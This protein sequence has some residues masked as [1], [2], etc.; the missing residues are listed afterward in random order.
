MNTVFFDRL[1]TWRGICLTEDKY[2][3]VFF[4][5]NQFGAIPQTPFRVFEPSPLDRDTHRKMNNRAGFD[6]YI[7]TLFDYP[8]VVQHHLPTSQDALRDFGRFLTIEVVACPF[9]CWHCYRTTRHENV[10][11]ASTS[12]YRAMDIVRLFAQLDRHVAKADESLRVLRISGGEPFLVVDLIAEILRLI[13]EER[14]SFEEDLRERLPEC[15]WTETNLAPWAPGPDGRSLVELIDD[16]KPG[17]LEILRKH[18]DR[19]IIHPCFHGLE[20]ANIAECTGIESGQLTMADLVAGFRTLHELGFP[21]YPTFIPEACDPD[22]VTGLFESLYEIAPR[23]PLQT[24]LIQV[25][26]YPQAVRRLKMRSGKQG[27]RFYSRFAGL[28]RW[29]RLLQKHYGIDYAQLPRYLAGGLVSLQRP[30]QSVRED[31]HKYRPCLVILKST[32]RQEY[33]REMLTIIGAPVGYKVRESYDLVHLESSL[34]QQLVARSPDSRSVLRDARAIIVYTEPNRFVWLPIRFAKVCDVTVSGS[35]ASFDLELQEY[36]VASHE[37]SPD[38]ERIKKF[39]SNAQRKALDYFGASVIRCPSPQMAW[40]VLGEEKVFEDFQQPAPEADG[41]GHLMSTIPYWPDT[42]RLWDEENIFIALRVATT[43]RTASDTGGDPLKGDAPKSVADLELREGE[44]L[45]CKLV[46]VIPRFDSYQ[47]NGRSVRPITSRTLV[48]ATST[49]SL[50]VEG[51]QPHPLTKYGVIDFTVRCGRL[52]CDIPAQVVIRAADH[53]P[54]CPRF[55]L[56]VKLK[57][58]SAS[59]C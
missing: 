33:R 47:Q 34:R 25:D 19:L 4:E 38:K 6:I 29:R 16:E 44:E 20:D 54:F 10:N 42:K 32:S 3:L 11:S 28:D 30:G 50:V 59:E 14:Q 18:Q 49:P 40:I 58:E 37:G 8:F 39:A 31:D 1:R 51:Y 24:A 27:F 15:I 9:M 2:R 45:R 46:Y 52:E 48:I 55:T 43:M 26:Y 21:L 13:T 7:H 12:S 17:V 57:K 41:W 56:D 5:D 22:G 23:Y 35:L 53:S 36:V